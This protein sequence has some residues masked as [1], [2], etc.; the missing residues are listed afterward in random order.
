LADP[1]EDVRWWAA[2]GIAELPGPAATAL[3]CE[4]LQDPA[5]SV[6]QCA[7]LGLGQ[8]IDTSSIDDL[9]QRLDD[10]DPMTAALSATALE[11]M[12]SRP[13]QL[14]LKRLAL[15]HIVYVCLLFEH[16]RASATN[17]RFQLYFLP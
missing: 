9:I 16:W 10:L 17:V 14:S 6:R 13:C 12:V 7:A 4:A 5:A 2:R 15:A 1:Q 11:K 8:L 3:L